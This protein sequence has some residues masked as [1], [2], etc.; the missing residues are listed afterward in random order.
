VN[1]MSV[2]VV[3]AQAREREFGGHGHRSEVATL[4]VKSG[5]GGFL[6]PCSGC[7]KSCVCGHVNRLICGVRISAT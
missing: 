4:G 5:N 1:A 2:I 3:F 7:P 6:C